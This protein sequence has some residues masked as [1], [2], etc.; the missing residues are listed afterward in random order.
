MLDPNPLVRDDYR[1]L[2]RYTVSVP[3]RIFTSL[4]HRGALD[5]DESNGRPA[6]LL[7]EG[8]YDEHLGL[9]VDDLADNPRD[10]ADFIC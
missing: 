5:Y 6:V 1:Q 4:D 8:L 9:R 7:E 2:Q 3:Q 10:P